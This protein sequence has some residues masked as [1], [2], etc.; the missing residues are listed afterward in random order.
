MHDIYTV[1]CNT[2]I[3]ES[4]SGDT[5]HINDDQTERRADTEMKYKHLNTIQ[6]F[7]IPFAL[8]ILLYIIMYILNP[9]SEPDC[10]VE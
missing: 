6:V 7:R 3:L 5:N 10:W 4:G 1:T 9:N 2:E 8:Y